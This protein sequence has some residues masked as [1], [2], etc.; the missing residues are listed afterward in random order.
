MNTL[1]ST[2]SPSNDV[3]FH[4]S[5][6]S[7]NVFFPLVHHFCTNRIRSALVSPTQFNGYDSELFLVSIPLAS[8]GCFITLTRFMP[9]VDHSS[10]SGRS[11]MKIHYHLYICLQYRWVPFIFFLSLKLCFLSCSTYPVFVQTYDVSIS[12]TRFFY[13]SFLVLSDEWHV[14]HLSMIDF[15]N[16]SLL[17]LSTVF[18]LLSYVSTGKCKVMGSSEPNVQ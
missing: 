18:F 14:L 3:P 11:L 8:P 13:V 16:L 2:S 7:G 15:H 4:E 10:R 12:L 17:F 5:A 6:R 9:H 1:L